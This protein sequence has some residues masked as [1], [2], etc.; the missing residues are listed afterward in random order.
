MEGGEARRWLSGFMH[1]PVQHNITNSKLGVDTWAE[2]KKTI[3]LFVVP[4]E[5]GPRWLKGLKHLPGK[6]MAVSSN[7]CVTI[8]LRCKLVALWM[9]SQCEMTQKIVQWFKKHPGQVWNP[10]LNPRGHIC[11]K[12]NLSH[13]LGS[14]HRCWGSGVGDIEDVSSNLW[15][16]AL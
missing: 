4:W 8:I 9:D 2:E 12:V 5:E 3:L 16:Y 13:N 10:E 14:Q 7:P 15:L 1:F 11:T 6:C